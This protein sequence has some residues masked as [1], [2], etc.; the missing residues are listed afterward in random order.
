V[1]AVAKYQVFVSSTFDDLR[2]ERDQVIKAVLEMGHIPVGMEMFSAADEEQW[3]II[4]RHIDESDYYAV[5]VAHRYGSMTDEGI[6]FTRKEYEYARARGIPCLGFIIDDSASW[7]ADR[8][9]TKTSLKAALDDLKA[10]IK[11]KPVN[12]WTTADDLHGKFSISLMKAITATPRPGWVRSSDVAGPEVTAELI[13][14]S[15]ENAGLRK[16]IAAAE[17]AAA[18]DRNEEI[19]RAAQTLFATK[20]SP[21]YRYTSRGEWHNDVEVSLFKIFSVL[22]PTMMVEDSVRSMAVTLAMEIRSDKEQGW[23]I[24]ALNQMRGLLADLMTLDLVHPSSRR[25]TVSD[26]NEYWSL[27]SLGTETLKR[28]RQTS[29]K[30][31]VEPPEDEGDGDSDSDGAQTTYEG[32]PVDG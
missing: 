20:R 28:I 19:R 8:V 26:D 7:P 5:V 22:A 10:L 2:D 27:S 32:Q 24:V 21:S 18:K 29:L 23:D 3:Q 4:A 12:F 9:D 11:E 31:A 25:H 14:L 16:G 15:S 6:S 13:R 1:A 30:D 17:A